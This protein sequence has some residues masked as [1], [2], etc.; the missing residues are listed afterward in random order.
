MNSKGFD[1]KYHIA[2]NITAGLDFSGQRGFIEAIMMVSAFNFEKP[3]PNP[4]IQS[5]SLINKIHS[6]H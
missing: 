3:T 4:V 1:P 6:K 2:N 5:N